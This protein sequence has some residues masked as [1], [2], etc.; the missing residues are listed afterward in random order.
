MSGTM[1]LGTLFRGDA[2]LTGAVAEEDI[3]IGALPEDAPLPSILLRTVS[4][5]DRQT[6]RVGGK[7]FVTE[8]VA[9]TIRAASDEDRRTIIGLARK[10]GRLKTGTIAGFTNCSVLTAGRGPDVFGANASFEGTQ[11][12]RVSFEEPA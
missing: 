6:L 8:R 4:V 3:Q 7:V 12:F 9:A 11:D 1:I 2:P 5:V 10:A